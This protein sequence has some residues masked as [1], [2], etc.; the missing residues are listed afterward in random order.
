MKKHFFQPLVLNF[1]RENK[2]RNKSRNESRNIRDISVQTTICSKFQRLFNTHNRQ[3]TLTNDNK[4]KSYKLTEQQKENFF[5]EK[6]K[7][8]FGRKTSNFRYNFGIGLGGK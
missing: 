6:R 3:Y 5:K 1:D 4:K 8:F 7:R 2:S